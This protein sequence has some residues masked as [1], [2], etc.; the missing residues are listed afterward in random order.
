MP[1]PVPLH[2][3]RWGEGGTRRIL[4]L[5]GITANA[6]GWWRVGPD[7]AE[8]G[9]AVTAVDLRGHGAS[10]GAA[11]YLFADQAADVL[12]L[13]PG[14][15]AVLGHS[16]GGTIAVLAAAQQPDWAAGLV[17]QDPALML[18][19]PMSEVLEWLL[20]E[21]DLGPSEERIAEANPQWHP[22]DVAAKV[23][24]LRASSPE[25]VRETVESNWNWMVLDEASALEVPTVIIGSDPAAGGIVPVA[26]GEWLAA[27]PWI[28][29]S[30]MPGSSHSTHRDDSHYDTYLSTLVDALDR[31]PTLGRRAGKEAP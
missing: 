11:S 19:E 29:Y 22:R 17:L 10:P 23:E 25:I 24:A 21:Y 5:H 28:E 3:I 13:G 7:L 8:R 26:F 20:E 27:S 15:D 6:T 16:M 18:P 9:W 2:A 31:L 1:S 14:W 12:A 4:L 30:M